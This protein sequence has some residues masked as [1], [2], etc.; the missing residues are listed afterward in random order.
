MISGYDFYSYF[1]GINKQ[2]NTKNKAHSPRPTRKQILPAF[3]S[4][5]MAVS[6]YIFGELLNMALLPNLYT[7]T[8]YF[9][10]IQIPLI[11]LSGFLGLF[12]YLIVWTICDLTAIISGVSYSN[13]NGKPNWNRARNV[14]IWPIL[15]PNRLQDIYKNWNMT[16][17]HWLNYYI[18]NR[19]SSNIPKS[20]RVPAT[21]VVA[22]IFHGVYP[23]YYI[24]FMLSVLVHLVIDKIYDTIPKTKKVKR[25]WPIFVIFVCGFHFHWILNMNVYQVY[26]LMHNI[27]WMPWPIIILIAL[28]I[29]IRK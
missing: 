17:E 8:T 28:Y 20:L 22:A 10:M 24:F 2:T 29:G 25:I 4:V 12:K 16:I 18:S 15:Y 5:A 6:L 1:L 9:S 23:G 19:L 14:N 13:M 3:K 21:R 27:Y 11:S 7:S 26:Q